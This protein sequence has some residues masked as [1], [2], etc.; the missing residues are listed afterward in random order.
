MILLITGI[1]EALILKRTGREMTLRDPR[2]Y[3]DV[4]KDPE[5]RVL[6]Y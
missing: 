5:Q 1:N 6:I 4:M 2:R 3:V